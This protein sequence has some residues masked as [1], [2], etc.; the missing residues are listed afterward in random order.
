MSTKAKGKR[1]TKLTAKHATEASATVIAKLAAN[2]LPAKVSTDLVDM[3]VGENLSPLTA[4][5]GLVA[6]NPKSMTPKNNNEIDADDNN[7]KDSVGTFNT[8]TLPIDKIERILT[9]HGGEK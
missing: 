4:H 1:K 9:Y 8:L 2:L 7:S 6:P 5:S 3:S